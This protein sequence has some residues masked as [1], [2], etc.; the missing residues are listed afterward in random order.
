VSPDA[1]ARAALS[2]GFQLAGGQASPCPLVTRVGTG[3]LVR[4]NG[5]AEEVYPLMPMP[6][7]RA[8]QNGAVL[9]I[10]MAHDLEAP[11]FSN[12]HPGRLD[13]NTLTV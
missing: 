2:D 8:S 6:G 11:R 5:E 10:Q 1:E 12:L 9:E 13:L 4:E 7:E 3:I